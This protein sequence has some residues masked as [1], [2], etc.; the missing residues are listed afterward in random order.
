MMRR[1]KRSALLLLFTVFT[2]SVLGVG[3]A[4]AVWVGRHQRTAPI[5]L[6]DVVGPGN[7]PLATVVGSDVNLTWTPS[8]MSSGAPV[9][10]YVVLRFDAGGTAQTMTGSC[11]GVVSATSCAAIEV[12]PGTWGFA[13]TPIVGYWTGQTSGEVSVSVPAPSLPAA[14]ARIAGR[15]SSA[16]TGSSVAPTTVV[17]TTVAPTSVAPTSVAPTT[18]AATTSV[19]PPT[20]TVAST[21]VAPTTTTAAPSAAATASTS[22]TAASTTTIAPFPST[23]ATAAPTTTVVG[24]TTITGSASSSTSVPSIPTSVVATTKAS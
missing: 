19:A 13:V 22:T 5:A 12:P 21:S 14:N 3:V 1:T 23:S 7:T 11:T 10:G 9:D 17:S 18:S 4:G 16:S 15:S 6:A 24:S 20:P 2:T 8:A